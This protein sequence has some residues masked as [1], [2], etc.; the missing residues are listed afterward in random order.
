MFK[1]LKRFALPLVFGTTLALLSPT[2]TYARDHHR[3]H[4]ERVWSE[5]GPRV[6]GSFYYGPYGYSNGYYDRWGYWHPAGGYYDR[7]GYWHPYGY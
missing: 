2:A 3:D 5:R 1:R 4:H 6:R 7:W